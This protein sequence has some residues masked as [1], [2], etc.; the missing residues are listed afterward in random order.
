MLGC[1]VS[2]FFY[3]FCAGNF[4]DAQT[5]RLFP[6]FT[7]GLALNVLSLGHRFYHCYGPAISPHR[8]T[9]FERWTIPIY[10]PLSPPSFL[11]VRVTL[12][13]C[14][15]SGHLM[16]NPVPP[17]GVGFSHRL[18]RYFSHFSLLT[19]QSLSLLNFTMTD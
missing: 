10:F 6:A 14:P 7:S 11:V 8:L 18:P 5:L 19:P 3:S 9:P 2:F 1:G 17:Y 12:G 13:I 4:S 16:V 15:V